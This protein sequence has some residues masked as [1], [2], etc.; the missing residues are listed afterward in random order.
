MGRIVGGFAMSHVLGAPQGVEAQSERVF[1][2]MKRLGAQLRALKPDVLVMISSDH[3]NNF[4]L[5]RPM[6]VGI[7]V[8]DAFTPYGDMGLPLH[9]I[10]GAPDF[11]RGLVKALK[12]R[13]VAFSEVRPDHGMMI[14]L[15]IVDPDRNLAVAPFYLNTV[16]AE[17]L[18]PA[19]S[20]DLGRRLRAYVE[21]SR[22]KNETVAI[23][24]GGGLSHWLGVPE[25]GRVN[26]EWDEDFIADLIEG[27]GDDLARLSNAEILREAGNGGLEVNAWI[28]LAGA[29]PG[30]R[31]ERLFYEAVPEWASG[32][33]GVALTP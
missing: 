31:G 3:L 21:T 18:E 4:S 28:A 5:K 9:P 17:A 2:G 33:G 15:G 12:G 16:F 7:A 24:A 29:M 1:A 26:A 30:C 8:D 13:A 25:E 6:P 23:L 22:P 10:R 11:A 19:Q 27:R 14:P 32:M 20:Y